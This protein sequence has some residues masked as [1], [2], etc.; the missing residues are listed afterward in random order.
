MQDLR[1]KPFVFVLMPFAS[2][3]DDVYKLG[4][5]PACEN[6]GAYAERID[7]QLFGESILDRI[8]NQISKAD[9]IVADMTGRNPNVFYEVGYAH[10]L[11]KRVILLTQQEKDIPFDLKHYP[12]IIYKGRISD[13][14]IDLEKRVRWVLDNPES[15][16]TRPEWNLQFYHDGQL[17]SEDLLLGYYGDFEDGSWNKIKLDVHNPSERRLRSASFEFAVI[18]DPNV[19]GVRIMGR[20]SSKI[21]LENNKYLYNSGMN[22]AVLPGGWKSIVVEIRAGRRFKPNALVRLV[23][24]TISEIGVQDY[25]IQLRMLGLTLDAD[26]ELEEK[27]SVAKRG[28]S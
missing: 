19:A 28:T 11:G 17:L 23:L 6:A 7:E 14:G 12:H 21:R 13:L 9:I 2:D 18:T 8:Y 27:R 26:S 10:A 20:S 16:G 24:R 4:I 25:P 1:P 5:K 22:F 15:Q 3:F